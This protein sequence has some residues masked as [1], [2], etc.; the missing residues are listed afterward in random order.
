MRGLA[1][2]L[3]ARFTAGV[4]GVVLNEEG[5]ILLVEHVFHPRHP[6]GLP[7]GWLKAGE[8]PEKALA[9]EINEETGLQV[10]ILR[11]LLVDRSPHDRRHLDIAFLC[12]AQ[13]ETIT[14]SREL[15][16]Y[17]WVR[18]EAVP[19]L[20]A[21]HQAAVETLHAQDLVMEIVK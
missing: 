7:G 5:R 14:L 20:I 3:S 1:G 10:D 8:R 9:R 17:D 12:A 15:L 18:P 13:G 21:F 11:P 4:V 6:W 19:T 16:D 2:F